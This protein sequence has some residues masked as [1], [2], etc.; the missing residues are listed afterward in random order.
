MGEDLLARLNLWTFRL[1]GLKDRREDIEPN[2]DY[3]LDKFAT[4]TGAKVTF[5]GRIHIH[6]HCGSVDANLSNKNL[7]LANGA[8]INTKPELEIYTDDVKCAHGAT[9]GELDETQ[10]FYLRS[11]GVPLADA[12]DLMVLAFLAEAIDEIESEDISEEI[13]RVL[14]GWLARRH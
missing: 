9:V 3:E 13:L 8:T 4:E 7:A 5:N 14:R 2:V 10:L 6:E 12:Q 1:P 11:R